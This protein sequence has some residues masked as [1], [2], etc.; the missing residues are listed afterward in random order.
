MS[1]SKLR[2]SAYMLAK[3]RTRE[4]DGAHVRLRRDRRFAVLAAYFHF[5]IG[6]SFRSDVGM[7]G[8][9]HRFLQSLKDSIQCFRTQP[10]GEANQHRIKSLRLHLGEAMSGEGLRHITTGLA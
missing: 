8:F 4:I 1:G 10:D 5:S 9:A 3:F 7:R 2:G 6:K